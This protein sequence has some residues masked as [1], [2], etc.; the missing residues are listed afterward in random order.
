MDARDDDFLSTPDDPGADLGGAQ[1]TPLRP[2]RP[3]RRWTRHVLTVAGALV[4]VGGGASAL[5]LSTGDDTGTGASAAGAATAA[6][7]A[8]P[9]AGEDGR[10]GLLERWF[11]DDRDGRWED[12]DHDDEDKVHGTLA[13][14]DDTSLTV[15]TTSGET[16]VVLDGATEVIRDHAHVGVGDLAAGQDVVVVERPTGPAAKVIVVG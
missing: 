1:Q 5:A 12:D 2:T 4:L 8:A 14:V 15:T 3:R 13:A 7:P 6:A 10:S 11:D 16:T 9:P